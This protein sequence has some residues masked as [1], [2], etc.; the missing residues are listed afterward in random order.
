MAE[1]VNNITRFAELVREIKGKKQF[2]KGFT[3]QQVIE[4]EQNNVFPLYSE[5][6]DVMM[7]VTSYT[8][9]TPTGQ[10]ETATGSQDSILCAVNF[11]DSADGTTMSYIGGVSTL[12]M[13]DACQM[14]FNAAGLIQTGPA[15]INQTRGRT[16]A[17]GTGAGAAVSHSSHSIDERSYSSH[18][19]GSSITGWRPGDWSG[20]GGYRSG[21][22]TPTVV[23][24]DDDG[25]VKSY[26]PIK[27]INFVFEILRQMGMWQKTFKPATNF[28]V[29]SDLR[30]YV[31][32][33][34]IFTNQL[35]YGSTFNGYDFPNPPNFL[36]AYSKAINYAIQRQNFQTEANCWFGGI[37]V[38][39]N[40]SILVLS[41]V[42]IRES[43]NPNQ[44]YTIYSVENGY[45]ITMLIPG[46]GRAHFRH[47]LRMEWS[48]GIEDGQLVLYGDQP[49]QFNYGTGGDTPYLQFG[50]PASA[51]G[52]G[53]AE[54]AIK[55]VQQDPNVTPPENPGDGVDIYPKWTI[56]PQLDIQ[57]SFDPNIQFVFEPHIEINLTVDY[58]SD[59]PDHERETDGT[60]VN[61][62]NETVVNDNSVLNQWII[63]YIIYNQYY[64][65]PDDNVDPESSGG[66]PGLPPTG[67]ATVPDQGNI[68]LPVV[69]TFHGL[70]GEMYN[71][72]LPLISQVKDFNAWLWSSNILDVIMKYFSSPFESIMSFGITY[73]DPNSFDFTDKIVLG[74][75]YWPANSQIAYT[76]EQYVTLNCG[77]V[78][79]NHYFNSSLDYE[80]FT[81]ISA[82]LPF[83]GVVEWSASD[84]M[85]S[86]VTIAYNIDLLTGS[87]LCI[88]YVQKTGGVQVPLYQYECNTVVNLPLSSADYSRIYAALIGGAAKAAAGI[89]TGG[90]GAIAM[91]LASGAADA[92]AGS[93]NGI[94]VFKSGNVGSTAGAMGPKTPYIIIR[95]RNPYMPNGYSALQ[96]YPSNEKVILG[97]LKGYTRV[98]EVHV[99]GIPATDN[100]LDLIESILKEG[101]IL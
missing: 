70:Q 88:V 87:S 17:L 91:G 76:T 29:H 67:D 30:Q 97:N 44:L 12:D 92:F 3:A 38:I 56:K 42:A 55:W 16:G 18:K 78:K 64:G 14:V 9:S 31:S 83:I 24:A 19:V 10:Y 35:L 60:I 90:A 6:G 74:P 43:D 48:C 68:G 1:Y 34:N 20:R 33:F 37:N 98:K 39:N 58:E 32:N 21:D 61:N 28:E 50:G 66:S 54:L 93:H 41:I 5:T 2:F 27:F 59:Q 62:N 47:T 96:G 72:Y 86:S 73:V 57:T 65:N 52:F 26:L 95:R 84:I 77:T 63:Y 25:N 89:A 22:Q 7:L 23:A 94:P 53:I 81:S 36:N 69:P 49:I 51:T 71:M 11:E 85:D 4:N 82:Y 15:V 40:N 100:E 75:T 79:I 8:S 13:A 101:V 99:E 46:G 45:V 80:P